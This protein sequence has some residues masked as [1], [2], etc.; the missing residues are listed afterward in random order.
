M[1]GKSLGSA[2]IPNLELYIPD[3]DPVADLDPDLAL[4]I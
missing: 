2:V 4:V 1:G 3:P